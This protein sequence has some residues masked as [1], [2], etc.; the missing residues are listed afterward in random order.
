[1]SSE[2]VAAYGSSR[3]KLWSHPAWTEVNIPL[4][5]LV[6]P[7][8][9]LST[10]ALPS[11]SLSSE[12]SSVRIHSPP[13]PQYGFAS[14]SAAPAT[15][16]A[17]LVSFP[18]RGWALH[19][20]VDPFDD[21]ALTLRILPLPGSQPPLLSES[22]PLQLIFDAHILPGLSMVQGIAGPSHPLPVFLLLV[23]TADGTVHQIS[24]DIPHGLKV[25][26]PISYRLGCRMN[27]SVHP[28]RVPT[29][30]HALPQPGHVL[31]ACTDGAI[32][33][34][35]LPL[36]VPGMN[37]SKADFTERLVNPKTTASANAISSSSSLL[38]RVFSFGSSSSLSASG[39]W[40]GSYENCDPHAPVSWAPEAPIDLLSF[41]LRMSQGTIIF[42]LR[43]DGRLQA[44]SLDRSSLLMSTIPANWSF[45]KSADLAFEVT[46]EAEGPATYAQGTESR[47]ETGYSGEGEEGS[48][49]SPSLLP[50]GWRRS[51]LRNVGRWLNDE[52][53]AEVWMWTPRRIIVLQ[54]LVGVNGT[55]VDV[56]LGNPIFPAFPKELLETEEAFIALQNT[57]NPMERGGWLVD[58]AFGGQ[59]PEMEHLWLL[60]A[61]GALWSLRTDGAGSWNR[62]EKTVDLDEE[63]EGGTGEEDGVVRGIQARAAARNVQVGEPAVDWLLNPGRFS[64]SSITALMERFEES[65]DHSWPSLPLA[66]GTG[67]FNEP[68]NLMTFRTLLERKVGL[69]EYLLKRVSF[70][71]PVMDDAGTGEPLIQDQQQKEAEE[72]RRLIITMLRLS[73]DR[74]RPGLA[75]STLD[76]L[77][78]PLGQVCILRP[79][80]LGFIQL[81]RAPDIWQEE[82]G[83]GRIER[84]EELDA[85][86]RVLQ[87][88]RVGMLDSFSLARAEAYLW[89]PVFIKKSSPLS[90][91][92]ELWKAA[93]D[94]NHD[95]GLEGM[96]D[97]EEEESDAAERVYMNRQKSQALLRMIKRIPS[98]EQSLARLLESL[99][100]DR[101][102]CKFLIPL[103][104]MKRVCMRGAYGR[105]NPLSSSSS[106]TP[107]LHRSNPQRWVEARWRGW[108]CE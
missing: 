59:S 37:E 68:M 16:P 106:L 70:A 78:E 90:I 63:D 61:S 75:L 18:E 58:F 103:G 41:R 24:L 60:T 6:S 105:S 8:F 104:A 45:F 74:E 107:L 48:S 13:L 50:S 27:H 81:A 26:R 43:R 65:Q 55:Q 80:S 42:A 54:V 9:T 62:V 56:N 84:D 10:S 51:L 72:W 100:M 83:E 77:D 49:S 22:K 82:D 2:E 85:W 64:R 40:N 17:T 102:H 79:E 25:L 88:V 5:D 92:K 76:F 87:A 32:L 23:L 39:N 35:S 96:E 29:F 67:L 38:K 47:K 21:C 52:P 31:V 20:I 99:D 108:G 28:T 98:P 1:M 57:Q 66:C 11:S 94:G 73:E 7:S 95:E 34:I 89:S 19:A 71:C 44:H 93:I 53:E 15:R 91:L 33:A 3:S 46:K 4:E 97:D 86:Y 30:L 14:L 101:F 69:R 36:P 12:S